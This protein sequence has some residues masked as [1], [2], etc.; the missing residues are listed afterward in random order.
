MS[1]L[2]ERGEATPEVT[3]FCGYTPVEILEAAGLDHRRA[4][5][6]AE[7]A[8][9]A[10]AY[11]HPSLCP[12]V[13]SCLAEG[14]RLPP[15]HHHAVFVNACDALRR[16]Y[17]AWSYLFPE[18]FV[19]LMDLPRGS[20]PREVEILTDEMKRL[21]EKLEERFAT[22]VT[23]EAVIEASRRREERRQIYLRHAPKLSGVE[24]VKT[25]LALQSSQPEIDPPKDEERTSGARVPVALVGNI[26]NPNGILR[27]LEQA[28]AQVVILDVCNGDRPFLA[29]AALEA[30]D[31]PYRALA[32]AYLRRHHCA[33]MQGW[34]G[35]TKDLIERLR[36]ARAAGLIYVTLKFCDPYIYEFPLLEKVL[37]EEGV[38][39]LRLESDYLDAHVGQVVTRVEAFLEMLSRGSRG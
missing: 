20:S 32:T 22:Q 4:T 15:G 3:W 13:R 34:Q 33:R 25:S 18:S 17:D 36:K 26:L 24:K 29:S 9:D 19:Y 8:E 27:A 37:E 2:R 5:G 10:D 39:T 11:L 1:E 31:D 21:A 7:D 12:Y 16:L 28:G 30:D 6:V 14:L 23:Q 35:R 38:K